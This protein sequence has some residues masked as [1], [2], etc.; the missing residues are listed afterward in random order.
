MRFCYTLLILCFLLLQS[1]GIYNLEV[2]LRNPLSDVNLFKALADKDLGEA[3]E[4]QCDME[5]DDEDWASALTVCLALSDSPANLSRKASLYHGR[6]GGNVFSLF[7][8]LDADNLM[9]T[10]TNA[11]LGRSGYTAADTPLTD[12]AEAVTMLGEIEAADM[13]NDYDFQLAFVHLTYSATYV[14]EAALDNGNTTGEITA[15]DID[16]MDTTSLDG[17]E[18]SFVLCQT[19][20][21]DAEFDTDDAV[22]IAVNAGVTILDPDTWDAQSDATKRNRIK[23]LYGF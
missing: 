18:D 4:Y 10:Y 20:L 8:S 21:N 22:L 1:C 12:L 5:I 23:S 9:E 15:A 17:F 7:S 14:N 6:A 16:T 3:T 2:S 13:T 11:L 19:G